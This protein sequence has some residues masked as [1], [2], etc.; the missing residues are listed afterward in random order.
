MIANSQSGFKN[1]ISPLKALVDRIE[2]NHV[3]L[4]DAHIFLKV[5]LTLPVIEKYQKESLPSPKPM[6]SLIKESDNIIKKRR[7]I[8]WQLIFLNLRIK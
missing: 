6:L 7:S 5:A 2:K 4:D 3:S 1:K 8:G